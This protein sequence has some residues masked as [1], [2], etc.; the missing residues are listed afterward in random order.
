M[1]QSVTFDYGRVSDRGRKRPEN[2]DALFVPEP[3]DGV[4]ERGA[5]FLIADGMGSYGNGKLAAT[6]TISRVTEYYYSGSQ[7]IEQAI[8][9]ANRDVYATAQSTPQYDGMGTTL[10]GVLANFDG[11]FQV[12][13][14]GDSR[15]YFLRNGKIELISRDHSVVAKRAEDEG[16]TW[17]EAAK[18]G[19]ANQLTRSIGRRP[20]VKVEF[21]DPSARQIL[22]GSDRLKIGDALVLCSDGMWRDIKPDEIQRT[23]RKARSAQAASEELVKLANERGGA[24]NITVVVIKCVPP[25]TVVPIE[26][27]QPIATATA[28]EATGVAS[29]VPAKKNRPLPLPLLLGG[30]AVV[31]V[32]LVA[33]IL[34]SNNS[35]AAAPAPS[36]VG[37]PNAAIKIAE[38]SPSPE[39]TVTAMAPTLA[40]GQQFSSSL[41]ITSNND[42]RYQVG[43]NVVLQWEPPQGAAALGPD[44]QYVVWINYQDVSGQT[45]EISLT[46]TSPQIALLRDQFFVNG[47]GEPVAKEGFYQWAVA[48]VSGTGEEITPRTAP[49]YKFYWKASPPTP[50]PAVSSKT[51][52]SA[53]TEVIPSPMPSNT[54]PV[55]CPAGQFWDPIMSRCK[56]IPVEPKAT[57]PPKPNT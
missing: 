28:T 55:T 7:P 52:T 19:K 53:P 32:L 40:A 5:L 25:D 36:A 8:E 10:V 34:L 1:E 24:D 43:E 48:V 6:S 38:P 56:S 27:P 31:A 14:V 2:E 46:T 47:N 22:G 49:L 44:Q 16:I 37:V 35:R 30:L 15:A 23:V 13:N 26:Q 18:R 11:R 9:T 51:P 45:K 54:P 12:F 21:L 3:L 39:T 41:T 33:L 29:H 4:R 42:A 17:E 57:K 50:V 20:E